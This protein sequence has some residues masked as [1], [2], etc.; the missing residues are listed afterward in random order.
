MN[1][2]YYMQFLLGSGADRGSVGSL[3]NKQKAVVMIEKSK[4]EMLDV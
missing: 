1:L 4:A 3:G 2:K